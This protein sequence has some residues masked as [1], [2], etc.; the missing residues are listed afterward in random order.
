MARWLAAALLGVL[1]VLLA[2][3]GTLW[4]WAGTEGSL[5]TA[6]RW[7]GTHLPLRAEAATGSLR[8]GGAVQRL[9]WSQNGLRVEVDDAELR[10]APAALLQRTLRIER[11]AARRILIDDRSPAGAPS[12]GPPASLALPLR[13]RVNALDLGELQW[14]GPPAYAVQDLAARYDYDGARHRLELEHARFQDGR[15]HARATLGDEAP[16]QLD[17]ALAGALAAA[18]PDAEATLPLTLQATLRG[19]LADLRARAD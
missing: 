17:L 7:A 12:A 1:V 4:W 6:L 8:A 3:M 13:V 18:L 15:W 5:A 2:A 11:L 14:A 16:I 9:V 10:W 19:P